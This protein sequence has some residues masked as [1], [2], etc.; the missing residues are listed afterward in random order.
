MFK[1]SQVTLYSMMSGDRREDPGAGLLLYLK[2]ASMKT[3]PADHANKRGNYLTVTLIQ[4]VV[5]EPTCP[6]AQLALIQLF[7]KAKMGAV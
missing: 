5:F 3:I 1:M 6:C 7:S 2:D 4:V